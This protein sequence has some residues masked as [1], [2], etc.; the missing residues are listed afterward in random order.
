[1][2]AQDMDPEALAVYLSPA[3]RAVLNYLAE[4][5]AGEVHPV[6]TA[7]LATVVDES[8]ENTTLD[9]VTEQLQTWGLVDA[10]S[11]PTE[12]GRTRR[13]VL[14]G[15]GKRLFTETDA[16]LDDLAKPPLEWSPEE[17]AAAP[18]DEDEVLRQQLRE[19]IDII[20]D[21]EARVND[22][23]AELA[24]LREPPAQATD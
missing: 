13:Y 10:R 6:V 19:T 7:D 8:V 4:N 2:G 18:L 24:D 17:T 15:R 21:L 11:Q 14:T 20:G 9:G 5:Y 22:L 3:Q 12:N 1:M 16:G 23:E